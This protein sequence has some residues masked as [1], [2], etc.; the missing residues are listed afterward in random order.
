MFLETQEQT[1]LRSMCDFAE[2]LILP[3]GEYKGMKFRYDRLPYGRLLHEAIDSGKWTRFAVTGPVQGGKTW[4]TTNI[5][6]NYYLFERKEDVIYG[7]PTEEMGYTKWQTDIRPAIE[8]SP[9]RSLLPT[10][11]TGSM[12][13]KN[14]DLVMFKNGAKLLFMSGKGGDANRS[15]AT[16]RIIVITEADKMDDLKASSDETNPVSQIESRADSYSEENQRIFMECTVSHSKGF[17]WTEYNNGTASVIHHKCVYCGEWVN[18]ERE[19]LLGWQAALSEGEAAENAYFVCP[20]CGEKITEADRRVMNRYENSKLVHKGQTIDRNGNIIGDEPKTRTLGFR[21]SAFENLLKKTSEFGRREWLATKAED[22]VSSERRMRQFVWAIPSDPDIE[23]L[24]PLIPSE[25]RQRK[26]DHI[27]RGICP[28]GSLFVTAGVDIGIHHCWA[29]YIAW[30]RSAD[31]PRLL[32][33]YIIDYQNWKLDKEKYT[34]EEAS[35]EGISFALHNYLN[36]YSAGFPIQGGGYL[37][38]M[39]TGIDSGFA[40]ETIYAFC[41]GRN[42]ADCIPVK[43]YGQS[44]RRPKYSKPNKTNSKV[45]YIG[46][47]YH[48]SWVAGAG[49]FLLETD[50]DYWKGQVQERLSVDVTNERALILFDSPN[51]DE[52]SRFVAHICSEHPVVKHT[53]TG[54]ALVWTTENGSRANHWL[55]S[56]AYATMVGSYCNEILLA[57]DAVPYERTPQRNDDF[58]P[59]QENWYG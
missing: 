2:T 55:D 4:H 15:G 40:T 38:L 31:N 57:S 29:T 47:N 11:G 52:H 46:N 1:E 24:R 32:K 20:E 42:F 14:V 9:Y 41:R 10:K 25:M 58:F 8:N 53:P 33:G 19:H 51:V 23:N 12:G 43:G 16:A 6:I 54:D 13:G 34:D 5:P 28:K 50:A 37:P 35:T 39:Y 56:T 17:I 18:I 48:K 36:Y 22:V 21:W 44:I 7:V 59:D 27:R 3:S 49:T 26:S 45:V 30:Q